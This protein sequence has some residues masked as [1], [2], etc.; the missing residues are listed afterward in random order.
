MPIVAAF[1]SA[2]GLRLNAPSVAQLR[3]Q[4]RRNI[5][6]EHCRPHDGEGGKTTTRRSILLGAAAAAVLAGLQTSPV[7]AYSS[8]YRPGNSNASLD[9]PLP[10]RRYD[11]STV[12]TTAS[13]LRYFDVSVGTED[14][15]VA[16][17]GS[18]VTVSYTT[19]L[20]GLNGVKLDSSLEQGREDFKF[21]VGDSRVVP[22]INEALVGMRVGG[23]RRAVLPPNIAYKT[24]DTLP[25]VTE[26]FARRRLLSVLETNRDAT[27]VVDLE[28]LRIKP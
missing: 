11:G 24:A 14:A 28:L 1:S 8:P 4:C 25:A 23:R 15:A 18:T 19:R 10:L 13:G 26:F 16:K 20:G 17:V 27:I 5:R 12:V 6:M 3:H 7:G 2:A 21:L 22:G 9:A